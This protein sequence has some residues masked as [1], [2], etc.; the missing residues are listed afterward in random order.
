MMP[1]LLPRLGLLSLF[2]L[3]GACQT[4]K[5]GDQRLYEQSERLFEESLEQSQNKVAPPPSVQAA[6]IPPL[7]IAGSSGAGP[8]FDVAV[9]D[10][11]ARDFFLSLMQSAGQNLLVHPEV[12]G[13]ITFSLSN[14]N[15]E[16]VLAAVRDSYGYDYRRTSYG[17]QIQPN[18]AITRTYDLNYL[19][20]QRLGTT[21]TR[22]SSGQVTSSD[23]TGVGVGG[24]TT[25][26]TSST[27]N[28]SQLL[29]SS[30]V[31]FWAEIREVIA[32]MI[33]AEEGN[34]VVV[35]PQAGLLVVRAASADQQAVENFLRQA[36]RNLQRQVILETKIL[37]VNLS[38]GF[39]A[40][41]NWSFLQGQ[42]GISLGGFATTAGGVNIP[43]IPLEGPDGIGGVFGATFDFGNFEGVVQLLETQG[44][45]RVLSSPR[46]STLN[47]Q[48]AVIKV[49]TDEFFVTDVSTTTTSLAGGTT[50]P[51]L[52]ITLTPFFSGISLDVTP[53]IDENDQITLHVRPTVSRVQDQ[54]KSIQ[55][56]SPDNVFNLPLALS[57]TRQSDSIVR[58]RSGQVVVIGGLLE[59]R[60][61][62]DDANVPWL[63]KLPFAGALFQQQRKS[64]EQTELVILM[65][66]QVVNDQVWLD[67]LRKS[68][69]SFRSTR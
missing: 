67:E 30:N 54:N 41:I 63:S 19:N 66:P 12:T 51:D 5:D 21:D 59:N 47:N 31:D 3:L 13:N 40:G 69:E 37:E 44:D 46:I 43:N 38:D 6:L 16:E 14:V 39:Q 15:L 26:S 57:T 25:S 62:N 58:A 29:T 28:A 52:D 34:Q 65:R 9:N 32:M 61:S 24:T 53:Q 7:D 2:C 49:G 50:A 18:Q 33:G 20:V 17:Y 4:F 22:V 60:N 27:V 1:T 23:N 45:V 35:N 64:L 56:G 36:Q 55:L 68:S 11:P 48:K 8:R 42:K 10:M